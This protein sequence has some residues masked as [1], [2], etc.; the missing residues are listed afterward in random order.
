MTQTAA[1][2]SLGG[3]DH[4][5][6]AVGECRTDAVRCVGSP[7]NSLSGTA[8]VTGSASGTI[9]GLIWPFGDRTI[10]SAQLLQLC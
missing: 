1:R 8:S 2:S 7:V 3:P 4:G 6:G 10:K 5:N 9:F